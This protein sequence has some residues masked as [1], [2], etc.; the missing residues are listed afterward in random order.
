MEVDKDDISSGYGSTNIH[1]DLQKHYLESFMKDNDCI[2]T[3]MNETFHNG[4]MS[5]GIGLLNSHTLPQ[6]NE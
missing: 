2:G 5:S 3:D 1:T 6:D 4:Y